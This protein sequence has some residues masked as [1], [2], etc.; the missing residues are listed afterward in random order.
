MLKNLIFI[1][2][3]SLI[4]FGAGFGNES[5]AAD[6]KSDTEKLENSPSRYSDKVKGLKEQQDLP[7]R[8]VPLI[9][10]WQDY[11]NEG[12][13]EHEFELPTGMV[14]S[15]GLI[16]Y[17]NLSTGLEHS[18]TGTESTTEWVTT[19][20]LF[21]NLT[22]SGTERILL[23]VSPLTR[24]TGSKTRYTFEPTSDWHGE[25]GARLTAAFFEGELSEM[26]PRLDWDGRRPLDYQISFGRQGVVSQGGIL[27][28][29]SMDSIA[30][31]RSTIPFTGTNF[32]RIG[33]FV[34]V[35]NVH[36]S[37]NMDDNEAELYAIFSAVEAGHA[38]YEL[39]LAY[40]DSDT[41][42]GDQFNV[43]ASFI[44][45]FIILEHDVDTTIRVANSSTPGGAETAAA[46]DGSLL[47]TSFSFAPKKTDDIVY[48]NAFGG[49]NN[50]ATASRMM[51]TGGPLS[52]VGLLFAGNGLA[53]A[54][55]NNFS[56]K[57]WGG[58]V[59]YQ[60][61]FSDAL[62]R[63]LILELG[64]KSDNSAGGGDR[65]GAAG[66]Y[67]QALGQH[68]FFEVGGYAVD[69]ESTDNAYGIRTKLNIVF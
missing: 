24:R 63:N 31:T 32:A 62:R 38:T 59:G 48:I 54:P 26:F 50:Y 53:G 47:Y 55:I 19:L 17:G 20:N 37:N 68:V 49:I 36:R 56:N 5:L 35:N 8:P 64:G 51:G 42:G 10:F 29:D 3:A 16:V 57:A 58:S 67:S 66:R 15:P 39:D 60:M 45:P 13:Y 9:E 34:G 14:V 27:I 30:I 11:V 1:G 7:P 33:G 23:G 46:T 28:N 44:H 2:A 25:T 61:F 22:L 12:P 21:A 4:A 41:A 52:I 43:G 18:D 6:N 69:Q 40:V 65:F